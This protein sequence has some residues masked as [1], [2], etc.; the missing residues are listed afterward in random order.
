MTHRTSTPRSKEDRQLE[1]ETRREDNRNQQR[2]CT[3]PASPYALSPSLNPWPP[4]LP[5]PQ[6]I[7]ARI[8][9][10]SS[11]EEGVAGDQTIVIQ[12]RSSEPP[13]FRRTSFPP[14]A[15]HLGQHI[16]SRT[17]DPNLLTITVS[18]C[19]KAR[20]GAGGSHF[21]LFPLP[22]GRRFSVRLRREDLSKKASWR[23]QRK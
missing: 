7:T 21:F 3:F 11:A 8:H 16:M 15:H 18:P 10:S 13:L 19:C 14:D 12:S 1:G 9:T 20:K 23:C 22:D 6:L 4:W 5:D 2:L 17:N